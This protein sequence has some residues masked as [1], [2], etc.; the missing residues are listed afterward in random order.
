MADLSDIQS[1]SNTKITG[2]DSAGNET[3][4]VAA[5]ANGGMHINLRDSAGTEIGTSV[6]PVTVANKEQPD[7]TAL[8][9]PTNS[10][11][12]VY[13]S[14][15]VIKATPGTLYSI[16]CFNSSASAQ[17][18]QLH[19][20]TAV[21][22]NGTVPTGPIFLVPAG[23]NLSISSDKFG[24]FFSSGIIVCNSTTGP[25]KTT[26]AADCWFDCQYQ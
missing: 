13:E 10:T 20:S 11:S 24:R 9:S 18:I 1:A 7:A 22:I 17:W 16:L 5:T 21:P 26:G 25:T 2:S 3:N 6:N 4:Y 8:F 12:T 23:G 14:S 19:N 15:R